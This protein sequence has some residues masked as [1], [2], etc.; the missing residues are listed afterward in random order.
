MAVSVVV[1]CTGQDSLSPSWLSALL[2]ESESV[3]LAS[4]SSGSAEFESLLGLSA[5]TTRYPWGTCILVD[6]KDVR[7]LADG[8]PVNFFA[9]DRE[10][11]SIEFAD[12]LNVRIVE[13]VAHGIIHYR[14][15]PNGVWHVGLPDCPVASSDEALLARWR[16]AGTN[17]FGWISSTHPAET[18]LRAETAGQ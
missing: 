8:R 6:G 13:S 15:I 16:S 4:V 11:L 10:S 2:S 5:S 9:E 18:Q 12:L 14:N 17:S 7:L 3:T 1:G